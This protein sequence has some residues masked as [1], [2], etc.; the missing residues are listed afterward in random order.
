MYTTITSAHEALLNKKITIKEL[1]ESYVS[2]AKEKNKEIFAYVEIFDDLDSQIAYAEDL[3][4]KNQATHLTGIPVAIKD[5]MLYKGHIS[6]SGS[7]I[8][9]N[10]K[11]VYDSFVINSLKKAGAI[12][13]GRTNMDEFAMG[14][15]T[16][17]SAFGKTKNPLDPSRVPGG[18]S[19]G[20]AAAVSMGG[21]IVSL[22]SDTGGS[23]RQPA[24]YCGLVGFKPTYGSVSRNGL[25]ALASSFDQIGP[26]AHTVSDAKILFDAIKEYD[27]NDGTSVNF[28]K[29]ISGKK[30]IKKIGVP[31]SW[32]S[33][34]GIE[35]SV[36][37]NFN[38]S[39]KI[40]EQQG[41]EIVDIDLPLSQ[42]SLAVYYILMPAEASSNLA[43]FDGIRYGSH[44]DSE[45][46]IDV[47][48]K[49][50]GF[51][52][53]AEVRRRILLGTYILSHGYYDAYYRSALLVKDAISKELKDIFEKVDVI[54]TPTTPF[55]SFQFGSKS[56]DPLAMKLS[57][58]FLAPANIAG[59]PA[60]SVPSG[61]AENNL[62]HSIHFMGPL[63]SDEKLFELAETFEKSVK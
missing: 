17:T 39:I 52:F 11:G 28:E 9:E 7:K 8:L 1:V 53:G 25:I 40:L 14:S 22:G 2:V 20:A 29:R 63:F 16:E 41:Y 42:A 32:V 10:Y 30:E 45:N 50:R 54:A 36:Q 58:L 60:I 13:I 35:P 31:R 43:R 12:I 4:A 24:A 55:L 51:N 46:L 23:I 26:L 15:S 47:Y 49:T 33:G 61:D 3:F 48:K 34:D 37:E 27:A 6:A 62:K 19:G 5:N 21:A 18:S 56:D 59:V 57:D 44:F 38:E